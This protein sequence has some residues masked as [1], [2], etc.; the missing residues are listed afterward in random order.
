MCVLTA[1][2]DVGEVGVRFKLRQKPFPSLVAA[3]TTEAIRRKE[4]KDDFPCQ[5]RLSRCIYIP[6]NHDTLFFS[7]NTLHLSKNFAY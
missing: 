7:T 5:L 4:S 3:V 1:S 6:A 2:A